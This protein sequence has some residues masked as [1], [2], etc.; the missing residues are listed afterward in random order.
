MAFVART[1]VA[2]AGV[3]FADLADLIEDLTDGVHV[4]L[5]AAGWTLQSEIS[6]VSGSTDRIYYSKGKSGNEDIYFRL[7][8]TSATRLYYR[9]Y[10]FFPF[11]GATG[12]GKN[13]VGT[14]TP[15][16]RA[17]IA[18]FQGTPFVAYVVADSDGLAIMY[19]NSTYYGNIYIGIPYRLLPGGRSG[20]AKLTAGVT[21]TGAGNTTLSVISTSRMV[22]N[23]K[24]FVIG[25]AAGAN[26]GNLVRCTI[27]SI[28]N[29][30]TMSVSNDS[31]IDTAFDI[32]A[33]IG[34]DPLPVTIVGL[35]GGATIGGQY[36][37]APTRG[38][39]FLYSPAT[40]RFTG[41]AQGA[42]PHICFVGSIGWTRHMI[43]A[44]GSNQIQM[45]SSSP[46]RFYWLIN[47]N[48]PD[49]L[50]GYAVYP[51]EFTGHVAGTP[52]TI[53]ASSNISRGFIRRFNLVCGSSGTGIAAKDTI[54]TDG[55]V[56][57]IVSVDEAAK[58]TVSLGVGDFIALRVVA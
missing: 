24:V 36:I 18:D 28:T 20:R 42:C 37:P 35:G 49:D 12:D 32:G 6:A 10:T 22:A 53:T 8:Q 43:Y 57:H 9:T 19:G 44:A 11:G 38:A 7:T 29:A 17:T 39:C 25:C 16:D 2:Y 47:D 51:Y 50:G 54:D 13:E 30:T 26:S 3:T 34:R 31:A 27:Q 45:P 15:G 46:Y 41:A 40:T 55:V 14:S 56:T 33:V 48:D 4:T 1:G 23:Q 58:A 5:L 21:I 52:T